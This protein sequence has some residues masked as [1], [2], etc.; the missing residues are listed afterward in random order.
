MPLDPSS[1]SRGHISI[2]L[3]LLG[4]THDSY[5]CSTAFFVEA[6]VAAVEVDVEKPRDVSMVP[7]GVSGYR[8]HKAL[9]GA[10]TQHP[11]SP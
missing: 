1:S 7:L 6:F 2:G 4:D 5:Q 9:D 3:M 11:S 8:G 10:M